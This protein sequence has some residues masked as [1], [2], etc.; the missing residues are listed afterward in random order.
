MKLA[1]SRSP[2]PKQRDGLMFKSLLPP[3]KDSDPDYTLVLDLDETLIHFS[4]KTIKA[5]KDKVE[6]Y[7]NIRPFA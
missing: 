1:K 4:E 7:F 6:E 2:S 5:S 3:K